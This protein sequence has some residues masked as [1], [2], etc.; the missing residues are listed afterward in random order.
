[1][2]NLVDLDLFNIK[3]AST[4]EIDY[5]SQIEKLYLINVKVPKISNISL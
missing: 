4:L 1:M 3:P 2:K 5:P